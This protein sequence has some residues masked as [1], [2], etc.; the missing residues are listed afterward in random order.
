MKTLKVLL[1]SVVMFGML[2]SVA[3]AQDL[4]VFKTRM[5]AAAEMTKKDKSTGDT[6]K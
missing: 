2:S 5:A 6:F 1:I 3:V 4:E